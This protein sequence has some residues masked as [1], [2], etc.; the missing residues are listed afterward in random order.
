MVNDHD[1]IAGERYAEYER[2]RKASGYPNRVGK[3]F[4]DKLKRELESV[5]THCAVVHRINPF[6]PN[7]HLTAFY[8]DK[9]FAPCDQFN[10][11]V[12]SNRDT[13]KAACVILN[14][15]IFFSQFFL[16]K[17]EST[18]R[19]INVRLY[20]L[21]G[22]RL[23]PE[24]G[25]VKE[26]S[27]VFTKYRNKEFPAL[28]EQ[29]DVNFFERYQEFWEDHDSDYTLNRLWSR[30]GTPVE[31]AK[32][33]PGFDMEVCK[34]VCIAITPEEL[35]ALYECFVKEMTITRRLKKD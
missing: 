22:M 5:E 26:L 33:R 20:D 9:T 28:C 27:R 21:Y 16:S 31:P 23:F 2:V 14:S 32:V 15:A 12:E 13:A 1:Y 30:I 3:P 19:F 25:Y 18:G 4:W 35:H 6:S 7:T 17:E 10:I 34:A 11:I 29:F 24:K 8:S